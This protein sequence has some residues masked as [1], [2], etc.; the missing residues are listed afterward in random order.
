MI[1]EC[2]KCTLSY[3]KIFFI[4]RFSSYLIK[5]QHFT[6]TKIS[7]LTLFKEIITVYSENHTK[8]IDTLCEQN[9][10]LLIAETGGTFCYDRPLKG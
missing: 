8:P 1:K 2:F 10:E 9:A 4:E 5:T 6:I 3:E 7:L